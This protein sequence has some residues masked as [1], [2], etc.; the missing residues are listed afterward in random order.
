[1]RTF[2]VIG[3]AIMLLAVNSIHAAEVYRWVDNDGKVHYS[4]IPPPPD[5]KNAQL[6]K[7]GDNAIDV[8]KLPYATRDAM[9]KN[10][11]VLFSNS[12]GTPCDQ[13]KQLLNKRGIPFSVKNPEASPADADALKK[14]IGGL[15]VPVLVVGSNSPLKGFEEGA[16]TSALDNAGYPTTASIVKNPKNQKNDKVDKTVPSKS[17]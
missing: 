8:D 7:V 10:P 15:E 14:L 3:A 6:K 4:D 12:C 9:K 11:V 13:A 5:A 17:P 2:L 16:W 1:M